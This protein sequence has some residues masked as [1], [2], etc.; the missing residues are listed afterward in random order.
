MAD[1]VT[2][3]LSSEKAPKVLL[4]HKSL[5]ISWICVIMNATA[6]RGRTTGMST[7]HGLSNC[8]ELVCTRCSTIIRELGIMILVVN[9]TSYRTVKLYLER[10]QCQNTY[11]GLWNLIFSG[12]VQHWIS[13]SPIYLYSGER[14]YLS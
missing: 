2:A 11:D 4:L 9:R 5:L 1:E 8:S 7:S 10:N 3:C 12:L 6:R 14:Y 13:S